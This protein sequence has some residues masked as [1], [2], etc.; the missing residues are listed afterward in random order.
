MKLEFFTLEISGGVASVVINRPKSRNALSKATNEELIRLA[1]HLASQND[2]RVCT[3]RGAEDKAFCTGADLKERK[4]VSAEETG[5]Y[6]DAISG[7]V[8]AWG[9]IPQPTIAIMNGHAFGGGLELALACDFRIAVL[10]AQMGLTEVRLGIM[11]GAGGSQRL[12]RLIGLA[13]AKELILCGARIDASR[14]EAIGLLNKAVPREDLIEES[15]ALVAKLL[16]GAPLSLRHSKKAMEDGFGM[17]LADALKL[18]RKHYD[19]TLFTEDRNEG[20][21]AFAEKRPPN[22]KGQ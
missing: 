21:L 3:I 1:E 13:R 14:A 10:G 16:A 15:Q 2:V 5:V 9:A 8:N 22:F 20:L 12:P 19:I 7:A 18:E 6:L 4:G 11:P 17:P